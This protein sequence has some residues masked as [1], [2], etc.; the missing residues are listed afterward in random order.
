VVKTRV[1]GS[2]DGKGLVHLLREIVA[3]EGVRWVFKGWL[4]SFVRL[5]PHTVFTFVALEQHKK[6][7]RWL[8]EEKETAHDVSSS[9]V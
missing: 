5:G 6:V 3:K 8:N 4:P 2:H 7:W 9:R 1:M